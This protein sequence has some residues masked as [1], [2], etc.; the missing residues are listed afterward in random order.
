VA[1]WWLDSPRVNALIA[2]TPEDRARESQS[3]DEQ[4]AETVAIP[5]P[6]NIA[7]LRLRDRD[8]AQ[9]IQSNVREQFQK[10]FARGY[11]ATGIVSRG[12]VA[13]YLLQPVV[14]V[15]A[16]IFPANQL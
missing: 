6:L 11:A 3:R 14:S 7:D 16:E 1:E 10:W 4:T 13:E 8:A 15:A 2:L 5:V 12:D 9:R